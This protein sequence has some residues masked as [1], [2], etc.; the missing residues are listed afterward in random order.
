MTIT[1]NIPK[2]CTIYHD[3]DFY[4]E[5]LAS[6]NP[7]LKI[8]Y[9]GVILNWANDSEQIDDIAIIYYNKLPS[10]SI[11]TKL[12]RDIYPIQDISLHNLNY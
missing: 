12:L 11:I 7:K 2:I 6:I 9:L 8:K 3:P 5:L 10:S 1:A 4:Q